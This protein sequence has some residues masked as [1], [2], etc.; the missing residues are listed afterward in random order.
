M[1]ARHLDE[2]RL[3]LKGAI[4]F[5]GITANIA[6]SNEN[7]AREWCSRLFGRG[8][9]LTPMS[10]LLAWDFAEEFGLQ[11]WTDP[12]RAGHSTVVIRTSD[13]D[14]LGS[15]VQ[16]AGIA[17]QGIGPGGGQRIL[18]VSDPDGNQIVFFGE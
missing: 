17:H 2:R 4:L 14:A 8:P 15:A 1:G 10:G 7:R 5:T 16:S 12:D 3:D 13:L 6:V 11:A 9:D 18:P